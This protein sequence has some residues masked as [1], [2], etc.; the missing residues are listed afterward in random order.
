MVIGMGMSET[1]TPLRDTARAI[2]DTVYPSD[3]WTP[4]GFD[5]A[6]RHDTVHYRNALCAARMASMLLSDSGDGRLL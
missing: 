4:V 3:E 1:V 2:Y 5:E 6:E